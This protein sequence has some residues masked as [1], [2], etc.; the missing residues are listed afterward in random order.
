M[1]VD[2]TSVMQ[3]HALSLLLFACICNS[4]SAADGTIK[5]P[6]EVDQSGK[7]IYFVTDAS[8]DV[9]AEAALFCQTHLPAAPS[10]DCI[11]KLVEQV[12]T[13]RKMRQDAAQQLP[14]ITFT[15]NDPYGNAQRFVHEE[16]ADA[17]DEARAFCAE[18][19]PQTD[20]GK[21]VE[22]ML[23]NA[24]RALDEVQERYKKTEL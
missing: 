9:V 14:G 2:G 15:V 11:A 24:A 21:C 13:I 1:S 8:S 4:V 20:E 7:S 19:F 17:A 10:N 12:A 18:H 6:V 16:G 3:A 23:Q 5:L 22:A